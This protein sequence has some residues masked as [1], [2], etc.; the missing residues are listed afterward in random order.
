MNKRNNET[1]IVEAEFDSSENELRELIN[2][3]DIKKSE[4]ANFS[5]ISSLIDLGNDDDYEYNRIS[6]S[7]F[8]S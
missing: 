7:S 5:D 4:T 1:F 8:S 6:E 2:Q 3:R